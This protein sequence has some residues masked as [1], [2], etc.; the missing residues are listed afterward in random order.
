MEPLE[1]GQAAEVAAFV[2]SVFLEDE[3]TS[4]CLGLTPQ[5]FG[6]FADAY[7]RRSAA[8]GLGVVARER[9]NSTVVGAAICLDLTDDV[10]EV[11]PELKGALF[12]P[13]LPDLA[14]VETLEGPFRGAHDFESGQ[15]AHVSQVAVARDRRGRGLAGALIAAAAQR[16]RSQGFSVLASVCTSAASTRAHE[17]AGFHRE[18]G[19]RYDSYLQE[20]RAVFASLEGECTLM[21]RPL[22]SARDSDRPGVSASPSAR[23][24]RGARGRRPATGG[25]DPLGCP[26]G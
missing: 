1:P 16:A 22:A 3:P 10:R 18:A 7:C 21:V 12:A 25:G 26:G 24:P 4:R 13:K 15:C 11:Y 14:F 8:C 2:A 5:V 19:L 17:K 9:G 6:P 20:G 23:A